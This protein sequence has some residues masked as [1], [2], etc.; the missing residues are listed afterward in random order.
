MD[1]SNVH[2]HTR[3]CT[4]GKQGIGSCRLGRPMALTWQTGAQQIKAVKRLKST[5]SV[6]KF[7]RESDETRP[8][9]KKSFHKKKTAAF[10]VDF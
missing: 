2:R 9:G 4:K 10:E 1:L 3:T 7:I 6:K 8:K 5:V